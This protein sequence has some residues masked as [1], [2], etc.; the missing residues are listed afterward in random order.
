MKHR[1]QLCSIYQSFVHMVH[2]QFSTPIRVF[3]SESGGKYL[4]DVFHQFLTSK[5]LAQLSYPGAHA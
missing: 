2:T 4:S 3:N 1:S 5:G